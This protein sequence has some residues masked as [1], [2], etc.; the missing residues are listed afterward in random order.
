MDWLQQDKMI[1]NSVPMNKAATN[2]FEEAEEMFDNPWL[3]NCDHM[4]DIIASENMSQPKK[5]GSNNNL[6]KNYLLHHTKLSMP[7]CRPILLRL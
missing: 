1:M 6:L 5:S 3:H 7:P 2:E 4:V